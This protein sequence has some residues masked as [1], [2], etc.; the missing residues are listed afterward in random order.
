MFE[1]NILKQFS[2]WTT[3]GFYLTLFFFESLSVP[4]SSS[5]FFEYEL[6]IVFETDSLLHT[7]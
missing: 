4:L 5:Y 2:K 1:S 3:V 6:D 7:S